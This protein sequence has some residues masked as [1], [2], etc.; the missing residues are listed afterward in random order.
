MASASTCWPRVTPTASSDVLIFAA[1][2][3]TSRS[4]V[5]TSVPILLIRSKSSSVIRTCSAASER[6]V[7]CEASLSRFAKRS[8]AT[9]NVSCFSARRSVSSRNC[10][11]ALSDSKTILSSFS[12]SALV[13]TSRSA[14][15]LKTLPLAVLFAPLSVYAASRR[16]CVSRSRATNNGSCATACN[17]AAICSLPLPVGSPCKLLYSTALTSSCGDKSAVARKL[18]GSPLAPPVPPGSGIPQRRI[19]RNFP[20]TFLPR[21]KSSKSLPF[22]DSCR[23]EEPP[24]PNCFRTRQMR[25]ASVSNVISTVG[26]S[27]PVHPTY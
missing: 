17:A 2:S 6:H 21:S 18:A 15:I 23:S 13:W 27:P 19:S 16:D 11:S 14:A 3:A 25:C 12:F 7:A 26:S 8:T 20:S 1:S 9:A 22:L 24:L 5:A 10:L 4:A